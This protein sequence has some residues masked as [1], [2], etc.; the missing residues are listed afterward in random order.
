MPVVTLTLAHSSRVAQYKSAYCF[1]NVCFQPN[2][3][4]TPISIRIDVRGAKLGNLP[5]LY[6]SA[7]HN[8]KTVKFELLIISVMSSKKPARIFGG[9]C[10]AV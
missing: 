10:G 8:E 3:S 4:D 5:W 1:L 9:D 7:A 2:V 6:F